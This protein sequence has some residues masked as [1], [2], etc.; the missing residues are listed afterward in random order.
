MP[1][2]TVRY[3]TIVRYG[4]VP[5][6]TDPCGTPVPYGTGTVLYVTVVSVIGLGVPYRYGMVPVRSGGTVPYVAVRYGTNRIV[7]GRL[8]AMTRIAVRY[9]T[10]DDFLLQGG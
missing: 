8:E 2:G 7:E 9:G 6:R 10:S 5:Y 4:I 3:G 1:Y